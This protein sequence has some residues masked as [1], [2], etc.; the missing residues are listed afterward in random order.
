MT[1]RFSPSNFPE[2]FCEMLF[3]AI[4]CGFLRKLKKL[5]LVELIPAKLR[6]SGDGIA[7]DFFLREIGDDGRPL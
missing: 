1:E 3:L 4:G 5:F 6:K 7:A 2:S